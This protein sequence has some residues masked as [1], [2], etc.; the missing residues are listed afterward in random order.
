MDKR[1]LQARVSGRPSVVARGTDDLY[2]RSFSV[3]LRRLPRATEDKSF[4]A[5]PRVARA[6]HPDTLSSK[7]RF[8]RFGV[9]RLCRV[10]MRPG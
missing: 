3:G 10:G 4:S 2:R 1:N 6:G 7:F 8:I 5:C 9:Y